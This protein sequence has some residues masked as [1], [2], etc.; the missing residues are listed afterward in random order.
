MSWAFGKQKQAVRGKENRDSV[1]RVQTGL[2]GENEEEAGNKW[3]GQNRQEG[4]KSHL[5]SSKERS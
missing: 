5:R 1:G 4:A 2:L 3:T